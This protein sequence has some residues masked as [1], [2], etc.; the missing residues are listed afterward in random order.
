MAKQTYK[1]QKCNRTFTMAA[2]LARHNS[3]IH[4]TKRAGAKAAAK[5]AVRRKVGRPKVKKA[6][7]M[8]ARAGGA[9]HL[10]GAMKA[11]HGELAARRAAVE[12]EIAAL[13]S[14]MTALGSDTPARGKARATRRPAT[15][16]AAARKVLV[17]KPRAAA[18]GGMRPGSLKS[19]MVRVLRASSKPLSPKDLA[20]GVIKV[21]YKTKSKNLVRAV[22][23]ALSGMKGIKRLGHGQY[24]M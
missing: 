12:G 24:R 21:G 22:S 6:T 4:G 3:T 15:K 5:A 18:G 10:L 11:Y 1:C 13:E 7:P 16:K 23:N 14:A 19:Y 2:H 8:L 9:V 20:A 17:A